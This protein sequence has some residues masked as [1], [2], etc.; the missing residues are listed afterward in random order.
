MADF[1]QVG[2]AD[3]FHPPFT[4][5]GFFETEQVVAV[6][7]FRTPQGECPVDQ[8][9]AQVDVLLRDQVAVRDVGVRAI[10]HHPLR[11]VGIDCFVV[12]GERVHQN[13]IQ[14]RTFLVEYG[15]DQIW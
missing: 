9:H 5:E 7:D 13:E 6:E 15:S 12:L 4:H 8:Q 11:V 3:P 1:D 14:D 2:L 10:F